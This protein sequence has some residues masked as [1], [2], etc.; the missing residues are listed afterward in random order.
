MQK[1]LLCESKRRNLDGGF[2]MPKNDGWDEDEDIEDEEEEEK[3]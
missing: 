3:W 1:H 2:K